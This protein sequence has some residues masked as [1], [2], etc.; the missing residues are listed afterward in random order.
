[1]LQLNLNLYEFEK[2]K[3]F[4]EEYGVEDV[5]IFYKMGSGIGTSII[6]K[7]NFGNEADLTDYSTW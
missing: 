6:A 3:E 7:D 2:L 4:M 1:M 5:T